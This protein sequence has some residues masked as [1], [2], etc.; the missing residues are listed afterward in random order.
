MTNYSF[1]DFVEMAYGPFKTGDHLDD[2]IIEREDELREAFDAFL[3]DEDDMD[4]LE[5]GDE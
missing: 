4:S 1:L 3:R 2:F 5:G